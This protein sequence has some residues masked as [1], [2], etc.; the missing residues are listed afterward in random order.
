MDLSKISAD[1]LD[2]IKKAATA[3]VTIGTGIHGVDL[4][5]LVSQI[6]VNTPTYDVIPRTTA[7][8]GATFAQW[9]VLL[10]VNNTQPDPATAFDYAAAL[11][12]ISMIDVG[13]PFGKV[14]VGYT[15]T[16][17]AINRAKGYADAKAVSVFN[18]LN[19]YK[20][21]MDKKL[22]G[23]QSFALATPGT[24]TLVASTT[25]GTIPLSTAVPV[26]VAARTLSNYHFGGSTAAS[27]QASVTTG[28]G[29]STNS[30]TAS[31]GVVWGAVAYDWY[32]NGFYY[33][34][35]TVNTVTITSVPTQNQSVPSGLPGLYSVAPTAV[36]VSDSSAK[37]NDFNGLLA[38]LT[39][40]YA[41]AGSYGQVTHGNGIPS[42]AVLQSL[43]GAALTVNGGN[44]AALDA[45]NEAIYASVEMSVDAYVMSS[46]TASEISSALLT[47]SA[48]AQVMFAPNEVAQR[49]DVVAGG[50]VSW[51]INKADG[52][53]P[54][55]IEVEPHLAPG[56][57]IGRTDSVP[58]PNSDITNTLEQRDQY[59]VADYEYASARIAGQAGGGPRFDGETYSTSA[60]I[61]RAPVSMGVICNIG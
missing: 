29:T 42:N 40:D 45:F 49:Q 17:D 36:P 20:I 41:N 34:T 15:V 18:A 19:Q 37:P 21:G 27:A 23:A 5:G 10:N 50:F 12:N 9:E 28:S 22:L 8:Q 31:V 24:P 26:K 59:P 14:G 56:I 61:N 57:I 7:D 16:Q 25:G 47:T 1:T 51:Y 33:T 39:G 2:Q 58:F 46:Q 54:I 13:S 3:G 55:K 38:T 11:A 53:S 60:L 43:D 52:G 4:S 30:V 44:V 48:G 6:P 32:V 35:T